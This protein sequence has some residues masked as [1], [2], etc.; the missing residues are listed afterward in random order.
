MTSSDDVWAQ[1][2]TTQKDFPRVDDSTLPSLCDAVRTDGF[3]IV[4]SML[5]PELCARLRDCADR[6]FGEQQEGTYPKDLNDSFDVDVALQHRVPDRRESGNYR[7]AARHPIFDGVMA[8]AVT[9]GNMI[10]MQKALLRSDR[11]LRLMQQQLVRSDPDPKAIASGS[12]PN[13]WHMDTAFLPK[14][15]DSVP[16]MNVHHVVTCLNKVESGGAAFMVVPGSFRFAK[17]YTRS[18]PLAK[19]EALR[20]SDFRTKLRP[21]LLSRID[22]SPG[23]EL[24]MDEGDAC[25]FDQMTC[26]NTDCRALIPL[27]AA[28]PSLWHAHAM[29]SSFRVSAVNPTHVP[30]RLV[31]HVL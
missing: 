16:Q 12:T 20:D 15:Y 14:H 29:Q 23:V 24:L 18:M 19:Q 28:N 9:A 17:E 31:Q 30:I 21:E 4:K 1:T 2:R 11:G 10:D 26:A 6:I 27:V 5:T 25:V 13:G 8:E 7:H 3:A 22:T